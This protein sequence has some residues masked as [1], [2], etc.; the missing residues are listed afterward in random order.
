MVL[1]NQISQEEYANKKH[2]LINRKKELRE[3][4]AAF[5][6]KSDNRFERLIRFI[7]EANQ[8]ENIA[9]RGNPE[10]CRDFLK[11]IGSNPR[12]GERTLAISLKNPFVLSAKWR[13]ERRNLPILL[14]VK[15]GGESGIRTHGTVACTHDFQ[16]C[17]FNQLLHLSDEL[18]VIHL[19]TAL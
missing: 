8:A 9:L 4:L 1:D 19:T 11:K 14:K 6:R 18:F 17:Q 3:K 2:K 13:A 16:S 7:K 10:Q 5:E 15:F 12:I